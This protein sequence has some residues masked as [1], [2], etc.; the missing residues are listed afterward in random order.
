MIQIMDIRNYKQHKYDEAWLIARSA[1]YLKKGVTHMPEL[2]PSW[3]LLAYR[4][5][6][7]DEGKWNDAVFQN[8]IAPRYLLEIIQ[9]NKITY[10]LLNHLHKAS[11]EG[12][13]IALLCYCSEECRCHRS[14]LAGLLKGT[15]SIVLTDEGLDYKQYYDLYNQLKQATA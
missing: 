3:D 9:N 11:K 2:A 13:R 1:R 5:N 8:V 4:A 12:K 10:P 14:V 7:Q 6:L 15:G